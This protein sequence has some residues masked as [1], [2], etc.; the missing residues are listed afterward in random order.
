[1]LKMRRIKK[2]FGII[3]K[4]FEKLSIQKRITIMYGGIF[5]FSII[6][7]SSFILGN[8][9]YINQTATRGELLKTISNIEDFILEGNSLSDETLEKLLATKYVEVQVMDLKDRVVYKSSVGLRPHFIEKVMPYFNSEM[10]QKD[11]KAEEPNQN[12]EGTK[13]TQSKINAPNENSSESA[14]PD[15]RTRGTFEGFAEKG[16]TK[17]TFFKDDD[18]KDFMFIEKSV[19]SN[20]KP[21]VIQVYKLMGDKAFYIQWFAFRLLIIDV[22]GIL[23]ALFVGRYIS[24]TILKP[25][26]EITQTAERISIE[27]LSQRIE[28]SGPDDEVKELK[29]TLNSMIE[30]LEVSFEK[31]NQF[32]SDA[33]HE[34]RTPISVIQG[35][36]NLINRWGKSDPN[37]LQESIDSIIAETNH[38]GTLIKKLLFL[39]KGDQNKYHIQKEYISLNAVT[40]EIVKELSVMD[41]KRTTS[42]IEDDEVEIY[43]DAS[44]IKQLL[45]IHTENS[46]KYTSDGGNIT[47][48]VFKDGN[49]GCISVS[50]DGVGIFSE[51]IPNIFNRFYRA[52][53]SR[54]KEIPGTGLG[55]S[56]AKWIT[57]IHNGSIIVDSMVQKGT[58]FTDKFL[59][60]D[61]KQIN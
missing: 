6:L 54:N 38:M 34:L 28:L 12:A 30:R 43:G 24:K 19:L 48:R 55:L 16:K 5:S 25:V 52:D 51:D 59:L 11:K 35:Y 60:P 49:F 36:A 31:Q 33:S 21:Y 53:K 9:A 37:I 18:G 56:I 22:L 58:T 7:I 15:G 61:K 50:D 8:A 17:E 42:L 20:N 40:A 46:I 14:K 1:M 47:F 3:S 32:V 26:K 45:W 41:I 23:A 4:N 2:I 27:D 13:S 44:L 29:L 10:E 57:D 39:A